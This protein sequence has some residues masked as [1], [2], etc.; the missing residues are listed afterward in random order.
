LIY[1]DH[2]LQKESYPIQEVTLVNLS[3]RSGFYGSTWC[4]AGVRKCLVGAKFRRGSSHYSKKLI[5]EF[6]LIS[7]KGRTV[8]WDYTGKYAERR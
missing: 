7:L 6:T 1:S 8:I 5:Q 2:L 4:G 3:G